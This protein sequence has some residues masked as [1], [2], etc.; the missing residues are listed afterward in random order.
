MAA[1]TLPLPTNR[2]VSPQPTPIFQALC[3]LADRGLR[4]RSPSLNATSQCY[5][6]NRKRTIERAAPGPNRRPGS[7]APE[8]TVALPIAKRP[9]VRMRQGAAPGRPIPPCVMRN[10]SVQTPS[11]CARRAFCRATIQARPPSL[12]G[13]YRRIPPDVAPC[14]PILARPQIM[15]TVIPQ[16]TP[17]PAI[18]PVKICSSSIHVILIGIRGTCAS[19]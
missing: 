14:S 3:V 7:S 4:W 17:L 6:G 16:T 8:A 12:V 10:R 13:Q 9:R 11:Q 2:D 5:W 15:K 19:A 1:K 18:A